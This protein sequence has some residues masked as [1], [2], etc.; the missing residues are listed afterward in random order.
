MSLWFVRR[1]VVCSLSVLLTCSVATAQPARDTIL[2]DLKITNVKDRTSVQVGFTFPVR[3]LRHYPLHEGKEV[4][5]QISPINISPGDV[6]DL[7]QR[8]SIPPGTNNPA[9]LIDVV[10]EGSES[11]GRYLTLTFSET[12]VFEVSQGADYRSIQLF[13]SSIDPLLNEEN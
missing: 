11:E 6:S 9:K 5:I 10:Y 4:R 1:I 8:E 7:F 12:M 3:Y 2:D 13:I